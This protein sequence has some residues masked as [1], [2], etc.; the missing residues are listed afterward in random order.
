[1]LLEGKRCIGVEYEQR[2][3][4]AAGATARETIL[5]AGGVAT[6]QILELSG[7]GRPEVL[8]R[9]GIEVLH[10]LPAVGENFRDHINARIIWRVKDPAGLLQPH[11]ARRR[12][13]DAVR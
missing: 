11:G 7:I 10:E 4:G 13:G 1:M 2:R 8:Q 3:R 6:P 5:S 12:R 9:H